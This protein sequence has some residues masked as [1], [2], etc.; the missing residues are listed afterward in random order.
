[1][2]I[3]FLLLQQLQND[4]VV[5]VVGVGVDCQ[6]S[7]V[8]QLELKLWGRRRRIVTVDWPSWKNW[9]TMNEWMAVVVD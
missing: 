7:V 6:M 4:T 3:Y 2:V 9:C 5:D 8:L 1:V